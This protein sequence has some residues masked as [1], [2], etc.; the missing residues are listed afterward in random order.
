MMECS[1]NGPAG[2][3]D[4]AFIKPFTRAG[5]A[6]SNQSE[7]YRTPSMT[8]YGAQYSQLYYT[9]FHLMKQRLLLAA[10][11]KWG[12]GANIKELKDVMKNEDCCIVGTIFKRMKLQ[13]SILKEISD[14]HAMVAHPPRTKYISEDDEILLEDL[15]HRV[16]LTGNMDGDMVATGVLVAVRGREENNGKFNVIDYCFAGAPP[17][18]PPSQTS[19]NDDIYV[20]LVSGLNIGSEWS[21]QLFIQLLVDYINGQLGHSK[22]QSFISNIVRVIIAG[23][24]ITNQPIGLKEKENKTRYTSKNYS[25]DSVEAMNE[26]DQV[27]SELAT[28]ISV[29]IMPGAHDP[30]N[31][32]LPKQ[33]L[34]HCM[35]PLS[36]SLPTLNNVTNPYQFTVNGVK[37]LG[38][39]GENI[40]NLYSYTNGLDT[41]DL[42]EKTL[43]WS[44][45]APTAPDTLS[46]SSIHSS[47][48]PCIHLL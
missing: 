30:A 36:S 48:H 5:A 12:D 40:D 7:A 14:N 44:H 21:D 32:Q 34:H 2:P 1:I 22:D 6:Y 9:R 13:P 15:A 8:R 17:I 25:A 29:D 24:S 20:L 27:M 35:F 10:K 3:E 26:L 16:T 11:N 4:E 46:I 37:F 18:A 47:I 38:T 45:L 31:N 19:N 39:C 23:N 28:S 43:T 42:L 41:I 33:P